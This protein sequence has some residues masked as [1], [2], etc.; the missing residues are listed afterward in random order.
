MLTPSVTTG[1]SE[2]NSALSIVETGP[3]HPEFD[4][5][6]EYLAVSSDPAIRQAMRQAMEETFGPYPTPTGYSDDGDAHWDISILSKYLGI[7]VDK[8]EETALELQEK[9][10]TNSGIMESEHLNL[11]H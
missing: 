5:A 4:G 1:E 10:G 11:V 3:S 6:W 9:W 8:I 2:L 7:P